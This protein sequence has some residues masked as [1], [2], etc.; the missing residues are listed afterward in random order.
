MPHLPKPR[1]LV[2]GVVIAL[3]VVGAGPLIAQDQ[4]RFGGGLEAPFLEG[5]GQEVGEPGGFD[6]E[7]TGELAEE[8]GVYFGW[9]LRP[10]N[11]AGAQFGGPPAGGAAAAAQP[12][13]VRGFSVVRGIGA[14]MEW[15]AVSDASPDICATLVAKLAA[16]G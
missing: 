10:R 9:G 3:L 11:Q 5:L 8:A 2:I 16:G 14:G 6:A 15:S 7:Q 4:E 1:T 12:E 13:T